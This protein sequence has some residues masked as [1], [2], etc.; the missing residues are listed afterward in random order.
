MWIESERLFIRN[1]SIEDIND[2]YEFMSDPEMAQYER[3]PAMSWDQTVQ[4]I[5]TFSLA[6]LSTKEPF[7]E[8]AIVLKAENRVIGGISMKYLDDGLNQAEI[9]YR[10]HW[11]Y[12]N[13]GY[14]TEAC[15][16]CIEELFRI[17]IRRV[18][19]G[20]LA[21]NKPSWRVM[22]KLGMQR[23][24]RFKEKVLINDRYQDEYLYEIVNPD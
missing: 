12:Q 15:R 2:V 5:K 3:F 20:T 22:E 6:A 16:T 23:I 14:A 19:A 9:G 13:K 4:F 21:I 8:L 24:A 7:V 10:I 1:Y 11:E 17:G 18:R